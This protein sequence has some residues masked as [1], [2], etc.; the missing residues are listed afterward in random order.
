MS[1]KLTVFTLAMINVAAVSSVR[2]WPT[3]AESGLASLFFFTLSAL[4]FFYSRFN[5]LGRTFYRVA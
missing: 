5:G 4:L 3:I 2:N 1:K